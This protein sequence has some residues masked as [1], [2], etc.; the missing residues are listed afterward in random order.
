MRQYPIYE[1]AAFGGLSALLSA[2]FP[3][4]ARAVYVA[5]VVAY[6]LLQLISALAF[7]LA[8]QNG[9]VQEQKPAPFSYSVKPACRKNWL[10]MRHIW[11]YLRSR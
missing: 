8:I 5:I 2:V 11:T 7:C 9:L 1:A 4:H 3:T 6:V 10:V